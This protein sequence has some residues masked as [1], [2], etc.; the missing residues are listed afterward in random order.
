MIEEDDNSVADASLLVEV[1]LS[2]VENDE[3]SV[4]DASLL[5]RV[6]LSVGEGAVDA[7]LLVAVSDGKD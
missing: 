6:A 7:S 5:E 2:V 1:G 4:T 3:D